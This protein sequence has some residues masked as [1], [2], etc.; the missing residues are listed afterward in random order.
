MRLDSYNSSSFARSS[1]VKSSSSD[2]KE[3][4]SKTVG[5]FLKKGDVVIYE[6][7]VYPGAT[8]EDCL[9]ILENKSGLKLN[10]DFYIGY[11]PERINP[12][13]KE[14]TVEKILKV[15]KEFVF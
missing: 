4:Q 7:T 12:G 13:D 1:A 15:I 8:E 10:H 3:S 11:S 6:S 5:T 2:S 14:H 9:P